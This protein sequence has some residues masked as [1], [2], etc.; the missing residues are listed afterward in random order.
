MD[1]HDGL[2]NDAH[3]EQDKALAV[4][5]VCRQGLCGEL[6]QL[7]GTSDPRWHRFGL[8]VPAEPRCQTE[9][10]ALRE[11]APGRHA[12]CHLAT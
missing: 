8:N 3:V 11:I 6:K 7:I 2:I 10:P 5:R 4:L 9:V 1:A 12:A